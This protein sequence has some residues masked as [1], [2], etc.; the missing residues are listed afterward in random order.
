MNFDT[1]L[2]KKRAVERAEAAGELAD[3]VDVR[4]ALL[5]RVR[6]E[7]ITLKKAQAELRK[8]QRNAARD[9]NITLAQAWTHG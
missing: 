5:V 2:R 6:A 4:R 3:T 8:I 7:E 1:R 9:G